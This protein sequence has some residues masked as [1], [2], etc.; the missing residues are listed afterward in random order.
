MGSMTDMVMPE[1]GGRVLLQALRERDPTIRVVMMSGHPLGE[2]LERLRAHGMIGW[3]PKPPS[4]ESLA[5][6]LARA[7]A[8]TTETTA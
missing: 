8:T 3:L 1:M 5:E 7:L 4:L 2:E 6:E